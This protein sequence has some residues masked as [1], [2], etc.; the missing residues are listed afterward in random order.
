MKPGEG[1]SRVP[2]ACF[3]PKDHEGPHLVCEEHH[4]RMVFTKPAG[5]LASKIKVDGCCVENS[6]A[7]DYLVHDWK[8][9]YHFVELK[10]RDV[11]K[12]FAQLEAS[13]PL[14][15]PVGTGDEFWC[16]VVCTKSPPN[17]STRKQIAEAK[18]QKKWPTMKLKVKGR[19]H[20]HH[21]ED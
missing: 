15:L 8:N 16:F 14:F 17:S 11:E 6:T 12:A 18:L 21:L 10:G 1:L 20:T 4:S 7:C 5:K 19:V 2:A 3:Q 9:R 13:I